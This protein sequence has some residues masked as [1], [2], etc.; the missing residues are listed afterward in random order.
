MRR[1]SLCDFEDEPDRLVRPSFVRRDE[2]TSDSVHLV[3]FERILD[4]DESQIR[5]I[6]RIEFEL[7]LTDDP[8]DSSRANESYSFHGVVLEVIN[9]RMR[10]YDSVTFEPDTERPQVV[11]QHRLT[12]RTLREVNQLVQLLRPSLHMPL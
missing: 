2:S 10:R 7:G 6:I 4:S 9:R 12:I 3:W 1:T 8:H 5:F 11:G